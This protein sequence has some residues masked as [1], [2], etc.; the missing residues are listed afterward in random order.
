MITGISQFDIKIL[1]KNTNSL[2]TYSLPSQL[3]HQICFC[4]FRNNENDNDLYLNFIISSI[5]MYKYTEHQKKLKTS[6]EQ[7][8]LT[9]IHWSKSIIFG[10][11]WALVPLVRNMLTNE[12]FPVQKRRKCS[13][14]KGGGPKI[15]EMAHQTPHTKGSLFRTLNNHSFVFNGRLCNPFV[16]WIRWACDLS[17]FCDLS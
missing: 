9:K 11:E 10:Y 8:T 16:C 3:E 2:F 1:D 5:L 14:I 7:L 17:T 12:T 6:L 15:T 4:F 13:K